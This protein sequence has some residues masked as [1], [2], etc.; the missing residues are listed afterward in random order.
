MHCRFWLSDM[1]GVIMAKT[2]AYQV[3]LRVRHSNPLV[4]MKPPFLTGIVIAKNPSEAEQKAITNL[5]LYEPDSKVTFEKF[6]TT[7]LTSHFIYG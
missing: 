6:K 7:K 4:K 2:S 1:E 5:R 3:K